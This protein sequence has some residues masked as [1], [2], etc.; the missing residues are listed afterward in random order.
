MS[1]FRAIGAIV[2]LLTLGLIPPATAQRTPRAGVQDRFW[3]AAISGDTTVLKAALDSGAVI[4][5]LDLRESA[6]GRRALNWAA[7]NDNVAVIRILLARG[8]PI[9]GR[10]LTLNTALHH[11]AE[12]GSLSAARLLLIAGA[13]PKAINL[14]GNSPRDVAIRNGHLEV[15]MM[16]EKAER[17][18]RPL[19]D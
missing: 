19:A 9:E 17:G 7:I 14:S 11:A 4:D 18:E 16:L 2:G 3:D 5:S 6:N 15:A 8:A 13:D 1:N 12:T 10:N